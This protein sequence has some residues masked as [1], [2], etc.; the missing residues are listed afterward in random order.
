MNRT[1]DSRYGVE[2]HK[3]VANTGADPLQL[4]VQKNKAH[5]ACQF[6]LIRYLGV[7]PPHAEIH[8][9]KE[10]AI[11]IMSSCSSPD[12]AQSGTTESVITSRTS[13]VRI[14]CMAHI[15]SLF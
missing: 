3:L 8:Q 10:V 12:R 2:N 6:C 4:M 9:G 14:L 1:W 15:F 11:N 13:Q 5:R 7:D